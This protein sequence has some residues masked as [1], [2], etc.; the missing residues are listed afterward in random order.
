MIHCLTHAVPVAAAA[1]LVGLN[2]GSKFVGRAF[3]S[4]SIAGLQFDAKAHEMTMVASL[5]I[6]LVSY[7]R[8]E[9]ISDDGLPF[10]AS[11]AGLRVSNL[12]RCVFC[13]PI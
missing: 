2:I 8:R 10:G 6:V 9:L 7:I 5:T 13:A 3:N 11:F 4:E 12:C 1:T